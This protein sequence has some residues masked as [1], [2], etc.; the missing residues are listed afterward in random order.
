MSQV[1][2]SLTLGTRDNTTP[3]VAG[4]NQ[5]VTYD[6]AKN[7]WTSSL[8]TSG[9]DASVTIPA[10]DVFTIANVFMVNP[11]T[12]ASTGILQQFTVISGGPASG[13]GAATLVVTPPIISS[14]PHQTVNSVPADTAAL[15]FIGTASTAYRQNLMYHKNAFALAVVPMEMP[16]AVVNGARQTYKG[17]SV[18]VIPIYDGTNDVSKWRMDILYAKKCI[19]QRLAT[20]LSGT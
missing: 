1:V 20:R 17:L 12:K 18:R 8:I 15:V 10:G 5:N 6:T 13:G 4:A 9:H 16:P 14:G 19:D 7:T 11:K 2:P 3:I